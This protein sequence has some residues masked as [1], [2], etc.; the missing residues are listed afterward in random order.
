MNASELVGK[1]AIRTQPTP[2]IGDRSYMA[3]PLLITKVEIDQDKRKTHVH[4]THLGDGVSRNGT[5]SILDADWIEG[6]IEYE[7]ADE[8]IVVKKTDS[9]GVKELLKLLIDKVL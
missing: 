6:W 8:Y 3:T 7:K 1:I 4:I 9:S 2:T 5:T